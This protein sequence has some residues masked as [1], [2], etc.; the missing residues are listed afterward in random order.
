MYIDWPNMVVRVLLD[1]DISKSVALKTVS[2]AGHFARDVHVV[3]WIG[4]M[5]LNRK[6]QYWRRLLIRAADIVL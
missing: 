1:I 6:L 5:L 3:D 4:L 2:I